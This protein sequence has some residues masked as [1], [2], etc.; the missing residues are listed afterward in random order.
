MSKRS[1]Q[2]FMVDSLF[3]SNLK[4]SWTLKAVGVNENI[5]MI[6]SSSSLLT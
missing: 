5:E 3:K 1:S 6:L 4:H 2:A